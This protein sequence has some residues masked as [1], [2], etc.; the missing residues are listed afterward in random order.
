MTKYVAKFYD[1]RHCDYRLCVMNI[2]EFT[3]R[4]NL[5]EYITRPDSAPVETVTVN[6]DKWTWYSM[7]RMED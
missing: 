2:T 5:V 6:T 3:Y 7:T 4:G 1:D